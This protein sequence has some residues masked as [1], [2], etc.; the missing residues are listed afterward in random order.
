LASAAALPAKPQP[1]TL[2]E[3]EAILRDRSP[4]KM[5]WKGDS[6]E[7]PHPRLV[8]VL[9]EFVDELS[10]GKPTNARLYLKFLP[11][12]R[13]RF[14]PDIVNGHRDVAIAGLTVTAKRQSTSSLTTAP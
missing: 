10:A 7:M 6:S 9:T 1:A 13:D 12:A 4:G 3:I 14:I 8:R 11:S 2:L 5:A